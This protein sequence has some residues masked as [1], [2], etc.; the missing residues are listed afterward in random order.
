MKKEIKK[1]K[2]FK[3]WF[4]RYILRNFGKKCTDF[5]WNCPTCHAH[6]VKEIFN[7]F[8]DDL[9]ETEEMFQSKKLS[10]DIKKARKEVKQGK[11]FT[12]E[13][14]EKKLKITK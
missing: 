2:E 5:T 1:L 3:K 11:V 8:V 7:D 13:K 14:V 9:T 10:K 4:D 12:L 6:F